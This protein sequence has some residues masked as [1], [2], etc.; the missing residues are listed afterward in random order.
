VPP[1]HAPVKPRTGSRALG[2]E[3]AASRGRGT[4]AIDTMLGASMACP[5]RA[6]WRSCRRQGRCRSSLLRRVVA[7][8]ARGVNHHGVD[9]MAVGSSFAGGHTR[10]RGDSDRWLSFCVRDR[11]RDFLRPDL[12]LALGPGAVMTISVHWHGDLTKAGRVIGRLRRVNTP[13][14]WPF[15]YPRYGGRFLRGWGVAQNERQPCHTPRTWGTCRPPRP[16]SGEE[17][18]KLTRPDGTLRF[19]PADDLSVG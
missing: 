16:R 8:G 2:A 13:E 3:D 5:P 17:L 19:S 11:R 18:T 12:G 9:V 14:A 10:W 4:S 6:V 15:A 7:A 1:D